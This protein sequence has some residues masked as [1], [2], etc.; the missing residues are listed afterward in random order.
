MNLIKALM[1]ECLLPEH[2]A[3][4]TQVQHWSL[5]HYDFQQFRTFD[6]DLSEVEI[7]LFLA[8]TNQCST[9]QR[10]YFQLSNTAARSSCYFVGNKI[11]LARKTFG[12]S[13]GSVT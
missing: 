7:V 9:N 8:H 13:N 4:Q 10:L 11:F 5:L 1:S 2:S 3:E 12:E 6:V